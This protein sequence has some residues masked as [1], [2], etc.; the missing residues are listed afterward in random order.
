MM[1]WRFFIIALTAVGGCLTQLCEP[2]GASITLSHGR[3]VRDT[4]GTLI[5]DDDLPRQIFS[6]SLPGDFDGDGRLSAPDLNTLIDHIRSGERD[7]PFDL[8]GDGL[9]DQQDLLVWVRDLRRTWPG[10][11]NLDGLFS[12]EDL[13]V[14][15]QAGEYENGRVGQSRWETGDW[16]GDGEFN[17]GD[18]V[19]ALQQGGYGRGPL[20][21]GGGR[22]G[23]CGGG[24]RT[25]GI[26]DCGADDDLLP[27]QVLR[28]PSI[29]FRMGP[30]L[31][32]IAGTLR[33][34]S[35]Q[36]G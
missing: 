34:C 21:F 26:C 14:V 7:S 8:S 29:H 23:E 12:D 33:G 28:W 36:V 1:S 17:S 4:L 32:R 35:R 24:S 19:F 20:S 13:V 16:T 9:L 10:D 15:L 3:G 27:G 6:A 31:K 5:Q 25:G 30:T 2:V 22:C 11:T 18:I